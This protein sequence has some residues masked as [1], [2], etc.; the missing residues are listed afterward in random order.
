MKKEEISRNIYSY[1][2]GEDKCL[3]FRPS[4]KGAISHDKY[5]SKFKAVDSS[6]LS[7]GVT[8]WRSLT[9]LRGTLS[10]E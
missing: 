7:N 3:Q 8:T 4:Q 9:T 10:V 5:N 2:R 6:E 1:H